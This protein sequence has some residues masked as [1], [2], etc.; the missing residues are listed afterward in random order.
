MSA[1]VFDLE[2]VSWVFGLGFG[3]IVPAGFFYVYSSKRKEGPRHGVH[4]HD[5]SKLV[6]PVS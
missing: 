1:F 5:G 6:D 4:D 2:A 3:L